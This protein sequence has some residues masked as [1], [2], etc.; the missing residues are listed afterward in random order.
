MNQQEGAGAGT[1]FGPCAGRTL[2]ENL[3]LL[4]EH[5]CGGVGGRGLAFQLV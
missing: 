4:E 3:E 1:V 2:I 5:C